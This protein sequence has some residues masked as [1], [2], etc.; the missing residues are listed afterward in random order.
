MMLDRGTSSVTGLS[1][2]LERQLL[3]MRLHN[4][5][6]WA[7]VAHGVFTTATP[8]VCL[9]LCGGRG[10]RP[11]G[12]GRLDGAV[13]AGYWA[14]MVAMVL[15]LEWRVRRIAR[16][17][18]ETITGF[19]LWGWLRVA[20]TVPLTQTVHFAAVIRF[21]RPRSPLARRPLP[22]PRGLAGAGRGGPRGSRMSF[23]SQT[24]TASHVAAACNTSSRR[25]R[26]MPLPS[27]RTRPLATACD[28]L[29]SPLTSDRKVA[30]CTWNTAVL[31]AAYAIVNT[32][33]APP[34]TESSH[35]PPPGP[36]T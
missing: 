25:R 16:A 9:L 11:I 28:A 15:P 10:N 33:Q 35:C 27:I 2:F 21:F 31:R 32:H 34:R 3:S 23:T 14:S 29:S 7:V 17:R 18:G 24:S 12:R 5:W 36:S 6:W 20:L 4:R 30:E 1:G 22:V 8:G 13:A 19:G 26:S